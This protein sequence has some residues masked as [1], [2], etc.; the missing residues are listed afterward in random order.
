MNWQ[1]PEVWPLYTTLTKYLLCCVSAVCSHCVG[2]LEPSTKFGQVIPHRPPITNNGICPDNST[3][4]R[5]RKNSEQKLK[6]SEQNGI[7]IS[8]GCIN[9]RPIFCSILKQNSSHHSSGEH[10]MLWNTLKPS[11]ELKSSIAKLYYL[12]VIVVFQWK[13]NWK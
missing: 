2:K 9:S 1:E 12:S 11:E 6:R 10:K 5:K 13:R 4:P 7:N 3:P 8:S